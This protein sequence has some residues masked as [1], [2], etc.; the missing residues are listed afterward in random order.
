[1]EKRVVTCDQCQ[2]EVSGEDE[3]CTASDSDSIVVSSPLSMRQRRVVEKRLHF[4]GWACLRDYAN[5]K[6]SKEFTDNLRKHEA[7]VVGQ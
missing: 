6:A 1:M 5:R 3:H 2:A 7:S 4:C